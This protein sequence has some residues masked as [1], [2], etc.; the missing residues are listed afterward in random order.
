MK[1]EKYR[2]ENCGRETDDYYAEDGWIHIDSTGFEIT[3]GRT[4][5][6]PAAYPRYFNSGIK[7]IDDRGVD[8]CSLKCLIAFLEAKM[9]EKK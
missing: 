3:K 4:K 2:C 5:D 1:V 6:G 7:S 9:E 8:F